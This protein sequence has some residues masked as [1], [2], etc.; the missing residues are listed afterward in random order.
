MITKN[1]IQSQI[2]MKLD[3]PYI[4]LISFTLPLILTEI[5][6]RHKKSHCKLIKTCMYLYDLLEK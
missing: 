6:R 5:S 2:E 4:C 1:N 3:Q